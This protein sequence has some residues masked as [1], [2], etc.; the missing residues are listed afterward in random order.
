MTDT[1]GRLHIGIDIGGTKAN[2]GLIDDKACLLAK[3]KIPTGSGASY[4]AILDKI[5]D[6][7]CKM[8][9]DRKAD[10][11]DVATIGIGVPGTVDDQTG[12]VLFAPNLNWRGKPV[13]RYIKDRFPAQ[14]HIAQDTRAAA[15]GEYMLGAGK[16]YKDMAC[17]TLG[18]GIGCGIIIDGRIYKG[19][20]NTAG[21]IGHTIVEKEGRLCNCGR[22]GCLEAYA[23]GIAIAKI[24]SEYMGFHVTTQEVF[25]MAKSGNEYA[26][27]IIN[28]AAQ[29]IG[30]GLVN[31][32]NLI[33][34]QAI[35][36]SGGMSVEQELL[37]RPIERFV[38]EHGYDLAADKVKI[39][40]ASLGEDAPMMGAA[41]LYV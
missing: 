10:I 25:A 37:V 36:I 11:A 13:V 33:S 6:S 12:M 3:T 39:D 5:I 34:P 21:E 9:S 38:R 1:K 8:V 31:L 26:Y 18:T 2:I 32:L 35:I 28:D 15:W 16:A 40:V 19:G 14:I 29:Y 20:L 24:A 4:E 41:M 17:V 23:G 30:M 22:N 27:K 7:I